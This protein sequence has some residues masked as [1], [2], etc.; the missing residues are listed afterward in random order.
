[1]TREKDVPTSIRPTQSS[2][3]RATAATPRQRSALPIPEKV[4]TETALHLCETVLGLAGRPRSAL[5]PGSAGSR[6]RERPTS[7]FSL[8]RSR[9]SRRM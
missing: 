8:I 1:V 2:K 5:S 3:G 4:A 6:D 9:S 7:S